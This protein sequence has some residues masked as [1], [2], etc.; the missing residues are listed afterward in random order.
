M[1]HTGEN[2][3]KSGCSVCH[4]R[5]GKLIASPD[6][7]RP[8]FGLERDG[9]CVP[10]IFFFWKDTR[11]ICLALLALPLLGLVLLDSMSGTE[12]YLASRE[13]FQ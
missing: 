7:I 11:V 13:S 8:S 6:S 1:V 10:G 2:M 12:K 4:N 3:E 5:E 9:N